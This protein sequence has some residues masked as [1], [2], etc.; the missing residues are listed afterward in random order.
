M[1]SV[2]EYDQEEHVESCEI[3]YESRGIATKTIDDPAD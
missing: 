1:E 3:Q 2:Q